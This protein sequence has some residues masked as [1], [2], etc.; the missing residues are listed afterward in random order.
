MEIHIRTLLFVVLSALGSLS[1]PFMATMLPTGADRT[2]TQAEV[3]PTPTPVP[4][5][6]MT[7]ES[8]TLALAVLS[9][10]ATVGALRS[11]IGALPTPLPS[12]I[13]AKVRTNGANLNIRSGPGLAHAIVG[14]APNGGVFSVIALS[15]DR[16]WLQIELPGWERRGWVYAALTTVDGNLATLPTVFGE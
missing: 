11:R 2:E 15:P 6:G 10:A 14:S 5:R 7:T 1:L 8:R 12:Q 13:T 9:P 3:L 4:L 16:Q